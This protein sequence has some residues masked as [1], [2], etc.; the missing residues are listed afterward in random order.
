MY[1]IK[2]NPEVTTKIPDPGATGPLLS[3]LQRYLYSI[4]NDIDSLHRELTYWDLYRIKY[5]IEDATKANG[6]I[7]NLAPGEAAVIGFDHA[8]N[9]NGINRVR[10][11]VVIKLINNHITWI[12]NMSS[13]IYA[14]TGYSGDQL[15]YQFTTEMPPNGATLVINAKGATAS[16]IYGNILNGSSTPYVFPKVSGTDGVI[17]PLIRFYTADNEIIDIPFTLD[18]SD[19]NNFQI[20]LIGGSNPLLSK[21]QV[22]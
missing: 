19:A 16:N 11:D 7:N 8:E 5:V 9:I 13:G 3:Q 22:K 21:I 18:S 20:N 6:I 15:L 10:G 14:P 2:N 17:Q 12:P 4:Q 1:I